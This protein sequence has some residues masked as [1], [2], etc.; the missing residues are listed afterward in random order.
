[1]RTL[2]NRL[3]GPVVAVEPALSMLGELR[4]L[5]SPLLGVAAHAGLNG[6]EGSPLSSGDVRLEGGTL[7]RLARVGRPNLILE[8]VRE[9]LTFFLSRYIFLRRTIFYARKWTANVSVCWQ[10]LANVSTPLF[11]PFVP[12]FPALFAAGFG[13]RVDD[14]HDA[15]HLLQVEAE[16]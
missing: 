3:V 14:V 7:P 2:G 6:F 16:R 8:L 1:V 4:V 13:L 15:G 5:A 12:A 10:T 11:F 9:I